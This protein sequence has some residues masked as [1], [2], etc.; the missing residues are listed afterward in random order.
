MEIRLFPEH[1]PPGRRPSRAAKRSGRCSR[2]MR[3]TPVLEAG[4]ALGYLVYPPLE[5]SESFHVGYD[6]EGRYQ[7]VYYVRTPGGDW[8]TIFTA[9]VSLPVG[10]FGASKK[11]V[12]FPDGVPTMPGEVAMHLV[13]R[14]IAVGDLGT[15]AGGI[16]LRGAWNF[17]TPSG[18][19]T[20][21][22]P[23]F[24]AIERPVVPMLVVRVETDWHAHESEFRYVLQPGEGMSVEHNMPSA[25]VLPRASKSRRATARKRKSR[26]SVSEQFS[27][28]SSSSP[29][30]Y[31]MPA[32]TIF[33]RAG[34][35]TKRLLLDRSRGRRLTQ[36]RAERPLSVRERQEVQAV[37][38]KKL[39]DQ[40]TSS[41]ASSGK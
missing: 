16:T 35:R 33:A 6:G 18:W 31:G 30:P 12:V 28:E 26:P 11:E 4:S 17:Q 22:A 14:F 21:Y 36:G 3:V 37:S 13:E 9:T 40:A 29:H 32:R 1:A 20:V 25:G 8:N 7:F 2:S 5:P 15:P 27:R 34:R 23:V 10:G 39:I 19:D 24:N 41:S 38:R